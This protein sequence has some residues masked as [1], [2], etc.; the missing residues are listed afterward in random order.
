MTLPGV[1]WTL[2]VSAPGP[3]LSVTKGMTLAPD[4]DTLRIEEAG[5]VSLTVTEWAGSAKVV[6]SK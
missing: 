4:S 1:G 2:N 5:L 3:P 6:G